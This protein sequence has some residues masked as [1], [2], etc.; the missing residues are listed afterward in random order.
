[1]T[2]FCKVIK[3][4]MITLVF[5]STAVASVG[6]KDVKVSYIGYYGDGRLF[7]VVNKQLDPACADSAWIILD[8]NHPAKKEIHSNAL[9]ALIAD[10][11]VDLYTSCDTD[12]NVSTISAPGDFFIVK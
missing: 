11:Y 5:T 4:I 2:Q 8:P 9:A 6:N 10:R 7:I 3:L 12:S 1:M